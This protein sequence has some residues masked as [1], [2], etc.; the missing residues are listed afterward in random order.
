MV[1]LKFRLQASSF[2]V[3]IDELASKL[4]NELADLYPLGIVIDDNIDGHLEF[5][6]RQ[7]EGSQL[8]IYEAIALSVYKWDKIAAYHKSGIWSF[9]TGATSTCSLCLKFVQRDSLCVGCPVF[10]ETE[11]TYCKGFKEYNLYCNILSTDVKARH[12][13]ALKVRDRLYKMLCD[14][15]TTEVNN[16]MFN[17]RSD[18]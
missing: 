14:H 17:L 11:Q 10:H 6:T 5:L 8:R 1:D 3:Y 18:R 12:K 2:P 13:A 7:P 9:S 4:I 15:I 16:R